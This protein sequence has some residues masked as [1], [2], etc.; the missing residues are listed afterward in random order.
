MNFQPLGRRGECNQGDSLLDCAR[1]LG[2]GISSI[3]GGKG[4][5]RS[6]KVRV[7]K[8]AVS[9]PAA[10]EKAA[11]TPEELHQGWRLAC[12]AYPKNDGRVEIPPDSMTAPQRTQ[13]EGLE[14]EF[15]PSPPVRA[16][17]VKLSPPSLADPKADAD[18]LMEA[19]HLRH[20]A[21]CDR[22]DKEVLASLSPALRSWNW[23]CQAA[24]RSREVTAIAPLGSPQLGLAVDLGSTKLAG[25]LLD[26]KSGKPLAAKGMMNPQISYGED[27]ISRIDMAIRSPEERAKLQTL[28]AE[29]INQLAYDLCAGV[30]AKTEHILEAVVVGNTA[31][32]HL[33]LGLP[34]RHL[35]L[36]PYVPAASMA[37]DY[38]A[39]DLGLHFADG[40]YVHTLPNIAGFVG[41]DHVAVLLTTKA[42]KVQGLVLA[43]DIG[44]NT[45]VSLIDGDRISSVSCASGPAFEGY[46]IKHG[47]RAAKGAIE[48]V[49]I[50]GGKIE[51][52]TI[53]DA[54]PVGICGSGVLDAMAQ[55]YAEGILDRG[56]RIQDAHPRVRDLDN[57]REFILV[58]EEEV[59]GR[60]AIVITQ[61]DIRH[62]QAAKAAIRAGIQV[63]LETH[64]RSDKDIENVIIAGAFG[65]YIDVS[66]AI[67]IGMLPSLP[68]SRFGQ[69]GNAA[70]MG[71]KL[72][73]VSKTMRKEAQT[74]ASKVHYVELAGAPQ[75]NETFIQACYLGNY[76]GK[77]TA[78]PGAGQ[79]VKDQPA[80]T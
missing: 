77:T 68:L 17:Q 74:L 36:S 21:A 10:S 76:R 7:L 39:R 34:V 67:T 15:R 30:D 78:L 35:A 2:A 25:Y 64:A 57:H 8:G 48:R 70:G 18:R 51:Y 28:A 37:L 62:L 73:L 19:L 61:Q 75:F 43:L 26:L 49:R 69:V 79:A 56:G 11:F 72:A 13:V 53:D 5:C 40:A 71:A 24:V 46:Q 3:C 59:E 27:I 52:Q 38:K 41:G 33:F 50:Q 22:I 47:M 65:S 80:E 55:M 14:I 20:K 32:H 45:E 29:A 16:Y 23:E 9:E 60:G 54:S 58:R 44:T 63:L 6:C 31:M 1:R 66:S 42:A 4:K 12:Q